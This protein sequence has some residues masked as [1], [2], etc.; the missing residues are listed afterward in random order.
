MWETEKDIVIIFDLPSVEKQKI[1]LNIDENV[2]SLKASIDKNNG[3]FTKIHLPV[4]VQE[5]KIESTFK[6]GV[7]E[8]IIPKKN[9]LKSAKMNAK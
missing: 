3:Y 4:A 6:N 7:L 1:D 2:L 5:N 9:V 8:V